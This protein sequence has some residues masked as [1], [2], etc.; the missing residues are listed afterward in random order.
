MTRKITKFWKRIRYL[1]KFS[2]FKI[3]SRM[4]GI[5]LLA[6]LGLTTALCVPALSGQRVEKTHEAIA[7]FSN[8][9]SL[10]QKGI[11]L[12]NAEQFAEATKSFVR[13][14]SAFGGRGDSLNQ[15]QAL[16]YLSLAYQHLGQWQEAESASAQSLQ[17]LD[18]QK[19]TYND[20]AYLDI[21][22]KAL[23]TQ[24]RLQWATGRL[25]DALETWQKAAVIYKRAGN[26]MGAIGSSI[27]QAEALQA[28]GLSSRAEVQLQTLEQILQQ[29]PDTNLKAEGLQSLGKALRRVGNLQKSQEVLRQ[30]WQV[31][32]EFYLK[33]AESSALLELGNTERALSNRAIAI[34]NQEDGNK[35][36]Q[37]A[38]AFYQ[39]AAS[40]PA[41]QLQAQLNLLSLLVD[42]EKLSEAMNLG[43]TIQQAIANLPAS[44]T[45]IYARI[46][47]AQSMTK[48]A[49]REKKI[50]SI[51]TYIAPILATALQQ[52][53]SLH[54]KRA[55][56]YSLGQLGELYELTQ[57]W[58][59]A[60]SL[61]QQALLLAG[62]IQ[63][64]DISYRWQWQL[65]RLL[66]KQGESE[67]V[68]ASYNA[69]VKDLDSV[70]GDLLAIDADV[71]F[72]FR[73]DVEPIYRKLVD[74]ILRT[75]GTSQPSQENLQQA[76]EVIDSLR[77]AELESFLRCNLSQFVHIEQD[78]N[79][80]DRTAAFLYPI[81]LEDRLEI[82]FQLPGQSLRHYAT[83]VKR[84]EIEK[85]ALAL[86]EN[87]LR[88]NHPE[89]VIENATQLY[90]WLIA[91]LE[92]DLDEQ[93]EVKTLVFVLDGV[94]RN[95]PMSVLYDG[96]RKEYLMQ[97]RYALAIVPELTL[98]DL[99]P[100]QR[101]RLNVLTAGVSEKEEV[102]G[103]SFSEL[104]NVVEELQQIGNIVPS[105]ILLNPT[106]TKANLQEQ[107]DSSTFSVVHI[108]THGQFSSDP[109]E[110]FI[111]ASD[112]L[113]R[114]NDLNDLLRK[115]EPS[116][117]QNVELLVLSACETAAGDNRA[118]LGLIPNPVVKT[119]L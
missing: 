117:R 92:Q 74:L 11:K 73:D 110:T 8:T 72:S 43:E 89:E 97:K 109:E 46:N 114:S 34:G 64:P 30:S 95:I 18:S 87:I 14:A 107:I 75:E 83:S 94:L 4:F 21:F 54:D 106:F 96:K 57:Q 47:F 91:P 50:D 90:E 65:G 2:H 23:N 60:Q 26:E 102:E 28:L 105:K 31:A 100:L 51:S 98:F 55:E 13:A 119:N 9:H 108:A 86:R 84:T 24:G 45:N 52:S 39:Q 7:P 22:A 71:Q 16:R 37:A 115:G 5:I 38:I 103:R 3:Y 12:Y 27:N 77:L 17:L 49:S 76:V 112:R 113:L 48:L 78:I 69:A 44:Q 32:K 6:L 35:H 63:A 70:K 79:K 41:L 33:N 20:R 40:S 10:L 15:A 59:N 101:D 66:E 29:Y 67:G 85:T 19:N 53:R 99:R 88:R 80:I 58:S 56:S 42:T 1:V 25:S 81:I 61:T 116:S 82:I 111:L 62:E 68:I 93:S 118:T 36:T 104:P